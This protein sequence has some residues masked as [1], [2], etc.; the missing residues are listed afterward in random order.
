MSEVTL[1]ATDKVLEITKLNLDGNIIPHNWYSQITRPNGKPDINAIIILAEILYWYRGTAVKEE[2]TGKFTGYKKKFKDDMLQRSYKSF[3][4][5]FGFSKKQIRTALIQ[6]E[7]LGL[8]KRVF[9]N[10]ELEN[11]SIITN[12]MYIDI[13][14]KRIEE[15]TINLKEST[16]FPESKQV[17]PEKSAQVNTYFPKSK[18]VV[19]KKERGCF[20]K[21]KEGISL[22]G[23]TYTETII[24][25]TTNTE[26]TTGGA[27]KDFAPE[28]DLKATAEKIYEQYANYN[29]ESDKRRNKERA[30]QNISKLLNEYSEQELK[31][32]AKNYSEYR[33]TKHIHEHRYIKDPSNFYGQRKDNRYFEDFLP[34]RYQHIKV[35]ENRRE[36]IKHTADL[37]CKYCNGTG[38]VSYERYIEK[39][40]IYV[41]YACNCICVNH[42]EAVPD[43]EKIGLKE[44]IDSGEM[45]L[46]VDRTYRR[47]ERLK[48]VITGE[49]K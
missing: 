9:K 44:E 43:I 23:N 39:E 12:V 11:K 19:T 46:D 25:E 8:I 28:D 41:N 48:L 17:F 6:L 40:D 29:K 4:I 27:K 3:E 14:P 36:R 18:E 7:N 32:A 20:P 15:I 16:S 10:I 34:D 2:T 1:D 31:A 33:T 42:S 22:K 45:I 24:T 26:N 30:I 13:N 49:R 35:K 37:S 5:Q 47:S 38:K 21:S